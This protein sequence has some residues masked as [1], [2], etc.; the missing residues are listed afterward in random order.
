MKIINILMG[1][2]VAV[3]CLVGIVYAASGNFATNSV[4]L[5]IIVLSIIAGNISYIVNRKK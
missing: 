3:L 1:I 5:V 4:G 2:I